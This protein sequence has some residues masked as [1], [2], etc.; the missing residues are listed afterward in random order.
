VA[1][2]PDIVADTVVIGAGPIGASAARHLSMD[3]QAGRVV[4]IGADEPE[5]PATHDGIFGAWHDE[6]RLTRI[7]AGDDVWATFAEES[8]DRY[9]EIR[10]AG[11]FEFHRTQ[12][13]LYVHEGI[14]TYC[15]QQAVTERHRAVWTDVTHEP[16]RFEY[17][18]FPHGARLVLEEGEAGT[19]NPRRLV[20][21]QLAGA[22]HNG[23]EVIRDIATKVTV[24]DG[25]VV[26]TTMDGATV[27]AGKVLLATGAY[28]NCFDLLPAPLPVLTRGITAL[29]YRLEGAV[30]DTLR[31]MPGIYW[32][33]D[34][35]D[36]GFVYTVPPTE[37]PDG[38]IYFKIGAYREI[39][40]LTSRAEIDAWQ[41]SNGSQP[42]VD[43]LKAWIA[44]YLP[45]LVSHDAHSISCVCTDVETEFPIIREEVPGRV[46]VAV[47]CMGAAAK[48]CDEIGRIAAVLTARGQWS[49]TLD[50]SLMAGPAR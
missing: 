1:L 44:N 40:E 50:Q 15:E 34:G 8:I 25:G 17:L 3:V 41:R 2:H 43:K 23:A 30:L 19:V 12:G 33:A 5:D 22:L 11:G 18:R 16:E 38:Y 14:D 10:A 26:I 42:E 9:P 39:N 35:G 27:R 24:A 28:V 47:G 20:A 29:F 4:V 13:V 46:F 31:D 21:N 49:S 37:Y 32:S 45:V 36:Y 6:A 7:I 48:S